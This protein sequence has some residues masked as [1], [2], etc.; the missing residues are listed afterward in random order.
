MTTDFAQLR[1]KM[2][3]NQIRT[4]DVTK[5]PV[6]AAFLT[7]ERERFVPETLI[8]LSY[9]DQD[10]PLTDKNS[11]NSSRYMMKP[12]ALAKLIQAADIKADDVVLDIGTGNGYS[13]AL[14]SQLA[15]SVIALESDE[16]L[17]KNAVKLLNDN[18]F[19]NVAVVLGDLHVGFSK[20]APYDVIF[21][22]G[23]VDFIPDDLLKQLKEGGRLVVVEGQGNAGIARVYIKED[24]V[25]SSRRL[26]NLAI[27]PLADFLKIPEFVF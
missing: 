2:V 14:F 4:V 17:S 20:E 1:L 23:S 27:Q 7:V 11:N 26:F 22:E 5:L 24:G 6:L 16:K 25:V 9:L 3:D 15:R 19:D 18:G 21:L 10:I 12:A 8:N 13:A